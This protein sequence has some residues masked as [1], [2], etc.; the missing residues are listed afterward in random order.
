M[1]THSD[2]SA[3]GHQD[4][5]KEVKSEAGSQIF[6]KHL[7]HFTVIQ[8]GELS[9]TLGKANDAELNHLKP[10]VWKRA[11][12][13]QLLGMKETFH[14]SSQTG[15]LQKWSSLNEAKAIHYPDFVLVF[16][17]ILYFKETCPILSRY[18]RK[19]NLHMTN[20]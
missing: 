19:L 8:V 3:H 10:G 7:R 13:W 14:Q 11:R 15:R 9:R 4:V 12:D 6:V 16:V 18:A 20:V 5:V 2:V 1:K 17:Q